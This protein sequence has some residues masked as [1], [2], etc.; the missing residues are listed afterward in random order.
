MINVSFLS[1]DQDKDVVHLYTPV[2][3]NTAYKIAD[4]WG[5]TF[6]RSP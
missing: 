4:P 3:R 5:I 6:R 1:I 2:F